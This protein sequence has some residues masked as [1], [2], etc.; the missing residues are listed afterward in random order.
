MITND[1]LLQAEETRLTAAKTKAWNDRFAAESAAYTPTL[2]SLLWIVAK[3]G[4]TREVAPMMN[5][6]K[7]TREC[8]N[9]Q[10]VMRE[11]MNWGRY[12]GGR[13]T[14]LFYFCL[15]GMTSSV[16]RMLDMKSIDMEARQGGR[17]DG[18]T[19]LIEAAYYGHLDI[20]RLL[21]DKG[22]QVN[23]KC[24][25]GVTP[26]HNT[27]INGY[28]ERVRLLCDHGADIEARTFIGWRPLHSA[29]CFGNISIVK[30]LIEVRN[31]DVNA[32]DDSGRT[33]LS[34]ARD[35]GMADIAAYL[36]SLGGVI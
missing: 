15:M 17:E 26:L 19:L 10:R 27:A 16:K 14:Q 4:Y 12:E 32:R 8:K 2:E 31:A 1:P 21:I 23:A 9:L 7:A 3:S 36:V 18:S 20:C 33:A 11:V 25:G 35:H 28:I 5:L 22:A 34:L 30:E 13:W 24:S 6:S 29:A